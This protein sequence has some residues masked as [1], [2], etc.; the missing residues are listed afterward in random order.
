[1]KGCSHFFE[2]LYEICFAFITLILT[3]KSLSYIINKKHVSLFD[4][5]VFKL[6]RINKAK[7]LIQFLRLQA[8]CLFLF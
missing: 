5:R 7:I 2:K 4:N 8:I 1:M 6:L 3:T